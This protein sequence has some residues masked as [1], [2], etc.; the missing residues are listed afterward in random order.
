MFLL[1]EMKKS[2][3]KKAMIIAHFNHELRN[4]ESDR[5]EKF[6]KDFC[7]KY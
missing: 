3:T 5:D 1:S 6:V 4:E 2:H 7:D